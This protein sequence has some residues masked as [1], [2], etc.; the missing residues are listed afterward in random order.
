MLPVLEP[1]IVP[2]ADP[3]IVPTL[4]PVITPTLFVLDPVI[5]PANETLESES[6]KVALKNVALRLVILFI[7]W[8]T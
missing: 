6:T 3:V 4:D 2:A 5:V 8:W 7:S 1:V